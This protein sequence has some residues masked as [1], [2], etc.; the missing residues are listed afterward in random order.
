MKKCLSKNPVVLAILFF[1]LGLNIPAFAVQPFFETFNGYTT[2]QYQVTKANYKTARRVKS[3]EAFGASAA[4]STVT[5]VRIRD[6]RTNTFGSIT[7]ASG[8]GKATGD[9]WMTIG[10]IIR[11]QYS[12]GATA[13]VYEVHGELPS[14]GE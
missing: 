10:D 2:N 4:T 14:S 13:A 3:I 6:G 8:A 12:G 7:L 5:L 9:V 1:V 11:P